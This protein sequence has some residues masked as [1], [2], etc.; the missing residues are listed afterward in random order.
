L[1]ITPVGWAAACL[2]SA[3]SDGELT[4]VRRI[5]ERIRAMRR[6]TTWAAAAVAAAGIGIGGAPP[7]AAG[8]APASIESLYLLSL[9]VDHNVKLPTAQHEQLAVLMGYLVCK[10]KKLNAV[11]P[12][13]ALVY[14]VAADD[15]GLCS[16]VSVD[17]G[18]AA[19]NAQARQDLANQ[20]RNYGDSL[21]NGSNA[22]INQQILDGPPDFDH[23]GVADSVDN[24][25]RDYN[26]GGY[27]PP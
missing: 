22:A 17:P 11:V 16:Y 8:P 27:D 25:P 13:D 10:T 9:Q 21:L 1:L 7:A 19:A 20:V 15:T 6:A 24:Y 2:H 23:D 26:P 5:T 12:D 3:H 4:G 14:L 18:A